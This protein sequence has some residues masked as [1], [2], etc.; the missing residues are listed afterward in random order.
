MQSST[1]WEHYMYDTNQSNYE[2]QK[3]AEMGDKIVGLCL[4]EIPSTRF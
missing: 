2:L 3:P 4:I 1:T